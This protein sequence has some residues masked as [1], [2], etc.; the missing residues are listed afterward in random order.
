[1]YVVTNYGS[2]GLKKVVLFIY[3]SDTFKYHQIFSSCRKCN[4][5][6]KRNI[7]DCIYYKGEFKT[8]VELNKF[9]HYLY[10]EEE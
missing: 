6:S 7:T 5:F 10:L 2:C 8:R 4:P 3:D 9:Y 1:M